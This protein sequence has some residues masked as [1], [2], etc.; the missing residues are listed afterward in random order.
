MMKKAMLFSGQGAQYT[1]MGKEFYDTFS[2]AREV[3]DEADE[4]LSFSLT[5]L[6]FEKERET[7]LHLTEFTQPAILTMSIAVMKVLLA[8]GV[9]ADIAAGLS[10]G[11]YSAYV[12]SGAFSFMDTV[13]LVQKR[14]RFMTEAVP[15]GKG[16]MYAIMGLTEENIASICKEVSQTGFAAPANYNAPGQI[17]IAGEA[18]ACD[19]AAALAKEKGAKMVVKLHVSGPFHTA[20]LRPASERLA[21][22]L[23]ELSIQKMTIPVVTNVTGQVVEK[24]DDIVPLLIQQV[25]SPVRWTDCLA[26]MAK[27]GADTFIEAGPGKALSGFVKRTLKGVTIVNVE[28]CKTLEKALEKING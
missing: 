17:V 7:D 10:L 2:C 23:K 24:E 6:C 5:K 26:T 25:M 11:E 15:A 1:G 18:A 9:S 19:E 22:L 27:M 3:F 12:A 8:H 16:S 21:V 20:L 13:R 28:D 4:A 14:G